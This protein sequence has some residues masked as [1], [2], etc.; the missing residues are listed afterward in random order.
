MK[1]TP[2]SL[3][4]VQDCILLT[5]HHQALAQAAR[6]ALLKVVHDETGIDLAGAD[7]EL[8]TDTGELTH[9]TSD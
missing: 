2:E 1:L 9:V 7:W 4:Q 6:E 3:R 5:Q 8:D